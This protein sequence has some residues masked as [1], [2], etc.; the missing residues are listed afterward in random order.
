MKKFFFS[1]FP[2]CLSFLLG[3]NGCKNASFKPTVGKID[4]I[5]STTDPV[6]K[7]FNLEYLVVGKNS[8]EIEKLMGAAD[9]KTLIQD[10][11]Y[12]LD[13]RRQV[14]DEASGQIYDWSLITFRFNQGICSSIDIL[15]ANKPIQLSES[16]NEN[17]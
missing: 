13:Y 3:L 5:Q 9:G 6:Y 10:S 4:T 12:L 1:I 15:L 16:T 14:L 7:K 8:S 11:Q 17:L 2:L